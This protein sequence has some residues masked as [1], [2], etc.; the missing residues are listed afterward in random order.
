MLKAYENYTFFMREV[1][2]KN[3]E[4]IKIKERGKITKVKG[5]EKT[6]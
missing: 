3:K 6:K 4:C 2:V 1:N 5:G